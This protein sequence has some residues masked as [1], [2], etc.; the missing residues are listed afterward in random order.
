MYI[1]RYIGLYTCAC[2]PMYVC[3]FVLVIYC[4]LSLILTPAKH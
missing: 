4:D 3:V 2:T 1:Y